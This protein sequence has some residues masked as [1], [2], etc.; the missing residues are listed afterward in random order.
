M[1]YKVIRERPR[2]EETGLEV[3]VNLKVPCL[4]GDLRERLAQQDPSAVN[5]HSELAD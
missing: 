5:E 1:R 3:R 4:L 2:E